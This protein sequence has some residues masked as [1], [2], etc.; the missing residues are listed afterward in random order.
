MDQKAGKNY[1]YFYRKTS[2]PSES[3][4]YDFTRNDNHEVNINWQSYILYFT[5][6]LGVV[7]LLVNVGD[8]KPSTKHTR[9]MIKKYEKT[10]DIELMSLD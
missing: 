10:H 6:L 3:D 4:S 2:R 1:D 5:G 7:Y 8:D 9:N